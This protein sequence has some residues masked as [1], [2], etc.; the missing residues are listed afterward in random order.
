MTVAID[1]HGSQKINP[2]DFDD[3]VPDSSLHFEELF[4]E[5]VL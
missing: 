5:T 3:G 4:K 2:N 1:I